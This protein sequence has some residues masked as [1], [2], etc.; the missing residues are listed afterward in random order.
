MIGL[1]ERIY[2]PSDYRPLGV[3]VGDPAPP[4]AVL[5]KVLDGDFKQPVSLARGRAPRRAGAPVTSLKRIT[6]DDLTALIRRILDLS[7]LLP[8]A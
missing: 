8:P 1:E 5:E 6:R 3:R 4:W 2:S 7:A